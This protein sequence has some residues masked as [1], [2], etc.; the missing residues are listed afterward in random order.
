MYANH[1]INQNETDKNN[2]Q[3]HDIDGL[4]CE[5]K[6]HLKNI[7]VKKVEKIINGSH[8][9]DVYII[10]SDT[11]K[12][13]LKKVN[14]NECKVIQYLNDNKIENIPNIIDI[15]SIKD[16]TYIL[17]EFITGEK[18][19]GNNFE[20]CR[21]LILSIAKIHKYFMNKN[22][23]DIRIIDTEKDYKE[24]LDSTNKIKLIL[25]TLNT[26]KNKTLIHDDLIPYNI[27][28]S[29]IIDWE[30]GS[31]GCWALDIGRF[32]GDLDENN[33]LY[34]INREFKER[35]VKEYS[36]YMGFDIR[37][38][39]KMVLYAEIY[40]YYQILASYHKHNLKKDTWYEKNF[41]MIMKLLV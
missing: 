24:I 17:E 15:I 18:L 36:D 11:K 2:I 37:Y 22:V 39:E 21:N 25:N 1:T 30:Y 19:D 6:K 4:Y 3:E 40:N 8:E 27:I 16:C 23:K 7:N 31:I 9:Y 10:I 41:E 35:L 13:I 32:F 33:Y 29:K 20:E 26:D 38:T 28:G 12:F 14:D 5:I 34:R